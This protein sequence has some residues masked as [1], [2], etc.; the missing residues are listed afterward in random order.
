MP[1]RNHV[2]EEKLSPRLRHIL[3]ELEHIV[4]GEGFLHFDTATLARRLGCSKRALYSLAPTQERLLQLVIDRVLNRTDEYLAKIA[5]DT[6]NRSA[7]LTHYM[8]AIVETSRPASARFLRDIAIFPP[9]MRLLEQLQRQTFDRLEKMIRDGIEAEVFNDIS[10][11]LV[12]ELILMAAGRLIDPDFQR[13]LG[14]TLAESYEELSRL[15]Y[16]GLLPGQNLDP[17]GD[18]I[19]SAGAGEPPPSARSRDAAAPATFEPGAAVSRSSDNRRGRQPGR[20][21]T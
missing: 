10:P 19:R 7:T 4:V 17:V 11:K 9:G 6:S 18:A 13:K 2:N 21:S 20:N 5:K 15:L 16:H 8:N 12:A 1:Q 14:L 3:A